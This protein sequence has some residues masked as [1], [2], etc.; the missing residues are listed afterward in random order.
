[1][2]VPSSIKCVKSLFPIQRLKALT[3]SKPRSL[4][5]QFGPQKRPKIFQRMFPVFN[6]VNS[7]YSKVGIP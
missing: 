7:W 5:C 6:S 3:L 2:Q 4:F 1:M